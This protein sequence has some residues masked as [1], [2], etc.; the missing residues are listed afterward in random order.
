M[1]QDDGCGL[2]RRLREHPVVANNG[3][4]SGPVRRNDYQNMSTRQV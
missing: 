2:G 1:S 3:L 4:R